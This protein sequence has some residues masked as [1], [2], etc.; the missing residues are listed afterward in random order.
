MT[1][2]PDTDERARIGG[3]L[4]SQGEKYTFTELWPRVVAGRLELLDALQGVSEQQAAFKPADDEWSIREVALHALN[5]SRGVARL[6]EPLAKGETPPQ[7]EQVDPA[8]EET[9]RTLAELRAELLSDSV[10][11]G[12]LAQTLPEPA[13]LERTALHI[14]FGE[15]HCRG[16]YLFQRVHDQDHAG[17]IGGI[18]EVAG[19]PS[20]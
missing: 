8:R 15:L 5:G 2:G 10:A 4:N 7:R 6:V 17:Q 16:W 11:F 20:Q 1:N 13:S 18:K 19:Y 3:Y 9:A 14:F 12:A